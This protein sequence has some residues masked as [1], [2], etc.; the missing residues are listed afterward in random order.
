MR[1]WLL[2]LV[3]AILLAPIWGQNEGEETFGID[4]SHHNGKINWEKVTDV[5][6]VYIKATEG[7]TYV[8]P[9]FQ[10]NIKGARANPLSRVL[11]V[12]CVRFYGESENSP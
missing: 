12:K 10:Q 6:F 3:V 2:I 7:A 9:L 11:I 4:V 5:E 8:D 1:R